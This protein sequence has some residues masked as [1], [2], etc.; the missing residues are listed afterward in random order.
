MSTATPESRAFAALGHDVRL[1]LFRLLVQA[2]PDGLNVSEIAAHLGL[3]PST[4]AHHLSALVA[5]GLV[6]QGRQGREVLNRAVPGQA[7]ALAAFL[8]H[9]CCTGI[10]RQTDAA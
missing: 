9:A 2:G 3:A 4:L 1:N 7:Q 8:T 6:S 10:T 5:A